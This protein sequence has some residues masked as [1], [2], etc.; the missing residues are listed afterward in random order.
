VGNNPL[1]FIDPN[2]NTKKSINKLFTWLT[3]LE[4][5]IWLWI[6]SIPDREMDY[7]SRFLWYSLIWVT[8]LEYS[9][10]SEYVTK[11]K[12]TKDYE[13][14]IKNIKTQILN[15]ELLSNWSLEATET[16]FA[17]FTLK[18][19]DY[20]YSA[21][22]SNWYYDINIQITDTYDFNEEPY[23]GTFINNYL[24]VMHNANEYWILT[25]INVKININ[26]KIWK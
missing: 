21:S 26:D 11:L 6:I 16:K 20:S 8:E 10:W 12:Q 17:I 24:N 14:L 25:P 2:G 5:L 18:K 15:W 9:E 19:Y 1:K 3:A 7:P 13:N 4:T 23:D 22:P